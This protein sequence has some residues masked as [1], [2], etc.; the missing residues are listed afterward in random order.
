MYSFV[1]FTDLD[2]LISFA[3]FCPREN[4][5]FDLG[6]CLIALSQWQQNEGNCGTRMTN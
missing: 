4:H 1:D 3:P 2:D 6:A 5:V